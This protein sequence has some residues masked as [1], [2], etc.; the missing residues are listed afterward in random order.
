MPEVEV[1]RFGGLEGAF[2]RL[3]RSLDNNLYPQTW[4]ALEGHTK[5]AE[6]R[7]R[8]NDAKRKRHLNKLRKLEQEK[9]SCSSDAR[10]TK[11]RQKRVRDSA[12]QG[13]KESKARSNAASA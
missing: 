5:P 3:K 13:R 7:K 6:Q 4:R 9:Q 8:D 10:M 1:S 12:V 2:R 11:A